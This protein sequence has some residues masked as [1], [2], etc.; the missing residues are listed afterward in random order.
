MLK[1]IATRHKERRTEAVICIATAGSETQVAVVSEAS[2]P[3]WNLTDS[4]PE[5][6]SDSSL[7]ARVLYVWCVCDASAICVLKMWCVSVLFVVCVLFLKSGMAPLIVQATCMRK[8]L[9]QQSM[10]KSLQRRPPV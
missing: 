5:A 2:L 4:S 8:E 1:Y 9:M 3:K 7:R 10:W 6:M